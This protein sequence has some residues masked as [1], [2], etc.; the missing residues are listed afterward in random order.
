LGDVVGEGGADLGVI[1]EAG[2]CGRSELRPRRVSVL[3]VEGDRL[4]IGPIEAIDGTPVIDIKPALASDH[5]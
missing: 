4:R 2:F 5:P 1:R 3:A